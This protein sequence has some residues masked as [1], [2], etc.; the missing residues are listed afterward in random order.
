[1]KKYMEDIIPLFDNPICPFCKSPFPSFLDV[2]FCP[3]HDVFVFVELNST[4]L[5]KNQYEIETSYQKQKTVFR[6]HEQIGRY[7][8]N[9]PFYKNGFYYL[10][11]PPDILSIDNT[12]NVTPD[13]FDLYVEKFKSLTVFL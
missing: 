4:Y 11:S 10:H 8:S 12:Y 3:N 1:M 2:L 7:D 9:N 5:C 13:N 6:K